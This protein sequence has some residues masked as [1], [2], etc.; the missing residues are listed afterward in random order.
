MADN[1]PS[2]PRPRSLFAAEVETAK[3]APR[4]DE[5]KVTPS[6][7]KASAVIAVVLFFLAAAS[8]VVF[9]ELQDV[10]GP[11]LELAGITSP[12]T[13][14]FTEVTT[15]QDG[16]LLSAQMKTDAGHQAQLCDQVMEEVYTLAQKNPTAHHL[17][18]VLQV[19]GKPAATIQVED[20]DVVRQ[21]RKPKAYENSGHREFVGAPLVAANLVPDSALKTTADGEDGDIIGN[22]Y[23]TGTEVSPKF[24]VKFIDESQ[25]ELYKDGAPYATCS[26][27]MQGDT[28][29]IPTSCN[30]VTL[31]KQ[32]D[33]FANELFH[34][35][36]MARKE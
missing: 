3:S 33:G 24:G 10:L 28:I 13:A 19:A 6:G 1:S 34:G 14:S 27:T 26:Y 31:H 22:F 9:Y 32:G 30:T 21:F 18:L 17:R 4:P 5:A 36:H 23:E 8:V 7:G 20:L 11:V 25:V 2:P 29:T 35:V 16:D 15:Q 12:A